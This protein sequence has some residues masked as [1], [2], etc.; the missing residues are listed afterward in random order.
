MQTQLMVNQ[1]ERYFMS[2]SDIIALAALTIT[3]LGGVSA[4]L[5]VVI[6]VALSIQGQ[7]TKLEASQRALHT[8][9]DMQEQNQAK[10]SRILDGFDKR[11]DSMGQYLASHGYKELADGVWLKDECDN[12]E[13][14]Y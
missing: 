9:M 2:A 8:R 12:G 6:K 3:I 10:V 4:G 11:L 7:L 13:E 5:G 14:H 1:D